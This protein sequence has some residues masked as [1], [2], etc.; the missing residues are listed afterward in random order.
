[1]C[2][3][4][5]RLV[6]AIY[7]AFVLPLAPVQTAEAGETPSLVSLEPSITFVGGTPVRQRTVVDAVTRYTESGLLL[8]DLEV[9]IHKDR[10][11]CRDLQG[12]FRPSGDI[13]LIDLCYG[14]EFLA[15]HELGHAWEHFN[16]DADGR[17]H[18]KQITGATTWRSTDIVWHQRGAEITANTLA[19]G[20]LSAPLETAAHHTLEFE[21][22]HTLTGISSPRLAELEPKSDEPPV[23]S[24]AERNRLAVFA[25]WRASQ[26]G[27]TRNP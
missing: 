4:A 19:H 14:G 3:V 18:F 11:G 9:H 26:T 21:R 8:P 13:A 2:C 1:M 17:E 6:A 25:A 15:L 10:T 5:G 22:F 23:V 7:I 20:L 24:E 27:P 12:S 16:L